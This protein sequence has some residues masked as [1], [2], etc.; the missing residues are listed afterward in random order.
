MAA[1]RVV[2]VVEV[3]RVRRGA[4]DERRV[5]RADAA[6]GAEDQAR[7]R[8]EIERIAHEPRRVLAAAGKRDADGI[9]DADLR[10]VQ[11]VGGHVAPLQRGDARAER[12]REAGRSGGV[13]R[14]S[15]GRTTT[16]S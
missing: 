3:E 1:E 16:R 5:E 8:R 10:P 15:A 2:A 12:L 7:T 14:A 6:R 4:V 9:E 13:R 11:R